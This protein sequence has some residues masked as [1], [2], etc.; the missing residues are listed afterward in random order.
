MWHITTDVD[1]RTVRQK[2]MAD[3]DDLHES[4][5]RQAHL[6][7]RAIMALGESVDVQ[8][9][10]AEAYADLA[11]ADSEF[12]YTD[13]LIINVRSDIP[14]QTVTSLDEDEW[15]LMVQETDLFHEI[16][17]YKWTDW[18][19]VEAAMDTVDKESTFKRYFDLFEDGY[20]EPRIAEQ[21]GMEDEFS[22][23][24]ENLLDGVFDP[25]EAMSFDDAIRARLLQMKHPVGWYDDLMSQGGRW[26]VTD[27]ERQTFETEIAPAL[28]AAVDEYKAE[29]DPTE[30]P[31]IVAEFVT[32]IAD[33]LDNEVMQNDASNPTPSDVP[34][35]PDATVGEMLSEGEIPGFDP[36]EIEQPD[37]PDEPDEMTPE[38]TSNVEADLRGQYSDEVDAQV[39]ETDSGE[40]ADSAEEWQRVVDATYSDED[41]DPVDLAVVTAGDYGSSF[42][43]E[44]YEEAQDLAVPLAR[45]FEQRLQQEQRQQKQKKRS[46]GKV[47]QRRLH[48]VE[49]GSTKVFQQH[50]E[51]DEK[52]YAAVIVTDRSG[53]MSNFDAGLMQPTETAAGALSIALEDVGVD[54]SVLSMIDDAV[55]L[56]KDFGES[57]EDA[58]ER[59]FNGAATG[60][61]P[62]TDALVLARE[63][64][65]SQGTH[66]F[67][68]VLTDG[69]PD[70]REAYRDQLDLCDFPVLGVYIKERASGFADSHVNDATLYHALETRPK[71]EIV[72]GVQNLVTSAV[73]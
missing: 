16:G 35:S 43:R 39:E 63:R 58:K 34:V 49:A 62:M 30:R 17:H 23:T 69:E 46:S 10:G 45:E 29:D 72:D 48:N 68:I 70:H 33:V 60:G 65:E 38:M 32:E 18:P 6:E 55:A 47:D 59:M 73:F 8:V 28:E 42:D 61:T 44:T 5:A 3:A 40:V 19:A 51:P 11:D 9:S 52:D 1:T 54:V 24:N 56:E 53:S 36:E 41:I 25:G 15:K 2:A 64:L 12:G 31:F 20:V 26:F 4:R 14:E 37:E 57:V 66:P 21:Y 13:R 27:D 22:L 67:L 7:S 71:D 50:S